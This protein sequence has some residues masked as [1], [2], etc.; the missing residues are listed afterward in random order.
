MFFIE[1]IYVRESSGSDS[2]L[3]PHYYL[4]QIVILIFDGKMFLTFHASLENDMKNLNI[5]NKNNSYMYSNIEMFLNS[6]KC[7]K[8]QFFPFSI[9]QSIINVEIGLKKTIK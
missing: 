6:I 7:H 4:L 9:I 8:K 5:N 3:K 1:F 2:N